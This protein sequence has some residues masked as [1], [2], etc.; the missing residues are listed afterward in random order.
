MF[1][2]LEGGGAGEYDRVGLVF[3]DSI[4]AD[5]VVKAAK[6]HYFAELVEHVYAVG[7]E[8]PGY[9]LVGGDGRRPVVG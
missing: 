3:A 5:E 4:A 1:G 7:V 2:N 8:A 6:V 9:A